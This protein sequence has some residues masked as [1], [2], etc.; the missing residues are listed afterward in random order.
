MPCNDC[1]RQENCPPC[2]NGED[3]AEGL[4]VARTAKCSVCGVAVVD[5]PSVTG[6]VMVNYYVPALGVRQ[7]VILC[8][9]HGLLFRE[10]LH[11]EIL[12]D[13]TYVLAAEMLRAKW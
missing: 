1:S 13:P 6:T 12:S 11:P 3:D 7:R 2:V 9:E 10:F 8:G 4:A 5:S